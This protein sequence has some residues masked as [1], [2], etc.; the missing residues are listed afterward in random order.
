MDLSKREQRQVGIAARRALDSQT[1]AAADDAICTAIL[2][3]EV[4]R[5]AD[6]ILLYHAA[7]GEV[8]LSAVAQQAKRDGK[9]VAWPVCLP[10]HQMVAAEP[11]DADAW[12]TGK[13]GI[14]APLLA[15]SRVILPEELALIL[16]PCTAF[17]AQCRRVGM[18][19][20]Y[21]DRYL[22]RCARAQCW[23]V[24][25]ECQRVENAAVEAHDRQ[26]DA[27]ISE[28]RIYKNGNNDKVE[29]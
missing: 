27:Y 4:Y 12:E 6:S 22:P 8:D 20:G 10:D 28:W 3:S 5:C 21:Y 9:R 16:V 7:G 11:A 26:L 15:R 24:A 23:G 13:Y 14:R 25:Y 2:R 19:A 18:G 17:D 1:R 29:L